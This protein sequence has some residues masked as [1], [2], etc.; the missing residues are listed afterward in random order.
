[1]V[2]RTVQVR[3]TTNFMTF[4]LL[5]WLTAAVVLY[6]LL[7]QIRSVRIQA[8]KLSAVP[9][10]HF[11]AP[12]SRFWLF[13]LKVTDSEHRAREKAHRHLGPVIRLAPNELS[14]NCMENGVQTIYSR[15]FEKGEWYDGFVNYGYV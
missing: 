15:D 12:Y 3:M 5:A 6:N 13:F 8:S 10:A 4:K 1:M 11:S 7:V 14:V 2:S 9:N